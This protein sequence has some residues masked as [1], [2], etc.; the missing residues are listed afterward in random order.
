MGNDMTMA[1]LPQS[2]TTMGT[3]FSSCGQLKVVY[4]PGNWISNFRNISRRFWLGIQFLKR[5]RR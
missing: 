3:V 2:L 4:H 1:V 5:F